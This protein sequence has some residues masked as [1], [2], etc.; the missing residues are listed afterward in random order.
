[1]Q[2]PAAAAVAPP[3]PPAVK[4]AASAAPSSALAGVKATSGLSSRKTAA[5]VTP[6]APTNIP[7][8]SADPVQKSLEQEADEADAARKI[9]NAAYAGGKGNLLDA[10]KAAG[11]QSWG[12]FIVNYTPIGPIIPAAKHY[13]PSQKDRVTEQ[14]KLIKEHPEM[15]Q[16]L[17]GGE[18]EPYVWWKGV[19]KNAAE[20]GLDIGELG[21]FNLP[22]AQ[23]LANT[24]RRKIGMPEEEVP[25]SAG[26]YVGTIGKDIKDTGAAFLE[27][28]KNAGIESWHIANEPDPTL[29]RKAMGAMGL[30]MINSFITGIPIVG[31]ANAQAQK[32]M[33]YSNDKNF[34]YYKGKPV[35]ELTPEEKKGFAVGEPLG[36]VAA[37]VALWPMVSRFFGTQL[38]AASPVL[39]AFAET[40]PYLFAVGAV[41]GTVELFNSSVT[42]IAGAPYGFGNTVMNLGMYATIETIGL[43]KARLTGKPY[44][45]E[46]SKQPDPRWI[47]GVDKKAA[48]DVLES[49]VEKFV[50]K[51]KRMPSGPEL[52]SMIGDLRVPGKYEMSWTEMN[53]LAAKEAYGTKFG[54]NRLI[55]AKGGKEGTPGID[56]PAALPPGYSNQ[57]KLLAEYFDTDP[58]TLITEFQKIGTDVNQTPLPSVMKKL[59]ERF[60]RSVD[61]VDDYIRFVD[62]KM[63]DKATT[64]DYN[65]LEATR[66]DAE[67]LADAT[68]PSPAIQTTM[69][70][71]LGQLGSDVT[72]DI[73]VKLGGKVTE[74]NDAGHPTI[75]MP[76][77]G[78]FRAG[79][80]DFG[81]DTGHRGMILVDIEAT[82][83]G[84]GLGTKAM[85]VIKQVADERQLPLHVA[86]VNNPGF[87]RHFTWL[88]ETTPGRGFDYVPKG[89]TPPPSV[90][91]V[92]IESPVM[93][94]KLSSRIEEVSPILT[95]EHVKVMDSL[96]PADRR[97]I[98]D[99]ATK[100]TLQEKTPAG[101]KRLQRLQEQGLVKTDGVEQRPEGGLTVL[102]TKEGHAFAGVAKQDLPPTMAPKKADTVEQIYGRSLIRST[103]EGKPVTTN[104]YI[105]EFNDIQDQ[106]SLGTLSRSTGRST[107]PE[108]SV[109]QIIAP[110]MKANVELQPYAFRDV[111]LDNAAAPSLFL[112][113]ADG[114]Q[115]TRADT[116]Y[117]NYFQKKYGDEIQFFGQDNQTANTPIT[118]RSADGTNLGL[119]MP[120]RIPDQRPPAPARFNLSDRK[121]VQTTAAAGSQSQRGLSSREVLPAKTVQLLTEAGYAAT[122][123]GLQNAKYVLANKDDW[124]KAEY[125]LDSHLKET[126]PKK[127]AKAPAGGGKGGGGGKSPPKAPAAPEGKPERPRLSSRKTK[128]PKPL[129]QSQPARTSRLRDRLQKPNESK[130]TEPGA[131]GIV[132]FLQDQLTAPIR[133]GKFRQKAAGIFKPAHNVVRSAN[134]LDIPT[135]SH[136]IGHYIDNE[137]GIRGAV[138]SG[139]RYIEP[140]RAELM[141]LG[142]PTSK[143]SYDTR[144]KIGEGIAEFVRRYITEP[145]TL[146]EMAPN[147]LKYFEKAIP[148]EG[149]RILQEARSAHETLMAES[150]EYR[151][152]S[153]IS[154][155][156]PAEPFGKRAKKT[157][158]AVF[159][160][161]DDD[162]LMI[163]KFVNDAETKTGETVLYKN[164]PYVLARLTRGM[165]GKVMQFLSPRLKPFD[166]MGRPLE[167][168]RSLGAIL[169]D[170]GHDR[171]T[172]LGRGTDVITATPRSDFEAYLV[173]KRAQD[174]HAQEIQTGITAA[175]ADAVVQQMETRHPNFPK[176]QQE[177]VAWNR[178]LL[179]YA[180][181][182]GFLSEEQVTNMTENGDNYVPFFRVVDELTTPGKGK[183]FADVASPFKRMKGST[184]QIISP[185]ESMTKNAYVIMSAVERNRVGQAMINL[186]KQHPDLGA[187]FEQISAGSRPIQVNVAEVMKKLGIE[188]PTDTGQETI[189]LFAHGSKPNATGENIMMVVNKGKAEYYSV[190]PMLYSA[191]ASLNDEGANII[192]RI[193]QKPAAVLRAGATLTPEFIGRNPMRDQLSAFMYSRGNYI[194]VVDF[195]KGLGEAISQGEDY[196]RAAI[197][198]A[199]QASF[200]SLD[201]PALREHV[202]RLFASRGEKVAHYFLHPLD[203]LRALSEF[204]ELGTRIGEARKVFARE[205]AKNGDYEEALTKSAYSARNVTIDFSRRGWAGKNMNM[206][207]AFWNAGVQDLTKFVRELSGREKGG[208]PGGVAWKAAVALTVP[209]IA[210]YMMSKDDE[211]YKELP[212]WQKDYFWIVALPGIP[213]IRV[214]KPFLPG[215]IFG[216]LPVR[217]LEAKAAGS[218]RPL[219]DFFTSLAES[220]LPG[221]TPTAALPIIEY[222]TNYSFFFGRQIV[223]QDEQSLLPADQYGIYTPEIYKALGKSL[224]L[225]PRKLETLTYGYTAGLG[226]YA[227]SMLDFLG[228]TTGVLPEKPPA[229]ADPTQL[230]IVRAFTISDLS[231]TGQ[232]ISDFY[233][234]FVKSEQVH[235][236]LNNAIND[237]NRDRAREI[238]DQNLQDLIFISP[239][240]EPQLLYDAMNITAKFLSDLKTERESVITSRTLT[241]QE[242]TVKIEK[243]NAAMRL[244]ARKAVQATSRRPK[245]LDEVRSMLR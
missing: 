148:P 96:T 29:R 210:F 34:L 105:L 214:P 64:A 22:P 26:E 25:D 172:R 234:S 67:R 150:P 21:P 200:V 237:S 39:N 78:K 8:P 15:A 4:P 98:R 225:S 138:K 60:G 1:M 134:A 69:K 108:S 2:K 129:E 160:A 85:E 17:N 118:V 43:A 241:P 52:Q 115:I 122:P 223:P 235:M 99:N 202:E 113:S 174:L 88:Q 79:F 219:R 104:T 111:G 59:G 197:G 130:V 40:H 62:K 120:M 66:I 97:F 243:I 245:S 128:Q 41:N 177:V 190:D 30:K 50:T 220:N 18:G 146:Q 217:M 31:G 145:E 106:P 10:V 238:R 176:L 61:D 218:L 189:T 179:N 5:P 91:S 131:A 213:L 42:K 135:I 3:P 137:F 226:R 14:E 242:K 139:N 156:R 192:M 161:I 154:T 92:R 182:R 157:V 143:P 84:T 126:A 232:S 72:R 193:L 119:I 58:S 32:V 233:E 76:D 205:Y 144:Q 48:V 20:F 142:E 168:V 227:T 162:L 101:I 13:F 194:P 23:S 94:P 70:Q 136:E 116:G 71:K 16:Q 222:A 7:P 187:Y 33:S 170:V 65:A 109:S 107:L 208:N 215:M 55:E 93:Q 77:G 53:A 82:P 9:A 151:V 132:K 28:F 191:I 186:A 231:T 211:R 95:Q 54:E 173:A 38:M 206:I 171:S 164:D 86:Y 221:V 46:F 102:V 81:E 110:A 24:F 12:D 63:G 100:S 228:S 124:S 56:R 169:E 149:I 103:Y 155:E 19:L 183:G 51:E 188:E 27:S 127:A 224:N 75:V 11:P 68:V 203:A 125:A 212:R 45:T 240:G 123:V 6:Q 83:K 199:M 121:T 181:E 185:I 87:F 198:G 159:A 229:P 209:S 216:S 178:A 165:D 89:A 166:G 37:G 73:A 163:R 195:F 112:R 236:S 44:R 196:Q 167:N 153:H 184:R 74:L 90:P 180:K 47:D 147:F 201:R 175:D 117:I 49:A 114:E 57:T 80:M 239:S 244:V 207:T 141:A 140:Y 230:P 133:T 158:D 152:K 35:R 204:G 36:G